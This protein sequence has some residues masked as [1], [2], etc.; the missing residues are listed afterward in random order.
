MSNIKKEAAAAVALVLALLLFLGG[1]SNVLFP[2]GV[3]MR[4]TWDLWGPFEKEPEQSLDFLVMGNSLAY[5]NVIPAQVYEETG[6]TSYLVAGPLQ[7]LAVTYYSLLEACKQQSPSAV[8]LEATCFYYP[9]YTKY[10]KAIV[11]SMPWTE[12]RLAAT[13]WASEQEDWPTLLFPLY[14]YHNRWNELT[15]EDWEKGLLGYDRD[16]LAGYS[17]LDTVLPQKEITVRANE[18]TPESYEWNLNY[19]RKIVDFCEE[20]GIKLVC[21]LSPGFVRYSEEDLSQMRQELSSLGVE[22]VDYN[23]RFQEMG[24]DPSRDYYDTSHLSFN[25]ATKFTANFCELVEETMAGKKPLNSQPE[26]WKQRVEYYHG[27]SPAG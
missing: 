9:K 4:A 13:F 7:T 2:K 22:L 19:L 8:F 5:C 3:K 17:Y 6:Y 16:I 20:R 23:E 12:N 26:L 15:E 10:T 21:F 25:G 1:S 18:T 14:G 11:G 27:L 24:M